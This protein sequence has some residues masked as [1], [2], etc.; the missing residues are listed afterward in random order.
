MCLNLKKSTY[1]ACC[2]PCAA[3][4]WKE[5]AQSSNSIYPCCTRNPIQRGS[6]TAA[7]TTRRNPMRKRGHHE[8]NRR[9]AE[10]RRSDRLPVHTDDG[11]ARRPARVRGSP[12]RRPFRSCVLVLAPQSTARARI[13]GRAFDGEWR[14]RVETAPTGRFPRW[15][16]RRAGLDQRRVASVRRARIRRFVVLTRAGALASGDCG[17]ACPAVRERAVPVGRT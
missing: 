5:F 16:E 8:H 10:E 6:L 2:R 7:A 1:F 3:K 12:A 4:C 9:S 11:M 17:A 13:S 14:V 15:D